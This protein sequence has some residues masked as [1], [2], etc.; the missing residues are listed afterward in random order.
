MKLV[1]FIEA[2]CS[3]GKDSQG[4]VAVRFGLFELG[5]DVPKGGKLELYRRPLPRLNQKSFTAGHLQLN[6]AG[7]WC[8]SWAFTSARP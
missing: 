4:R 1:P 8:Y 7:R 5:C 2:A 6:E 3:G